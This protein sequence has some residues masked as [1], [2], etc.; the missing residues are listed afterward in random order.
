[1]EFNSGISHFS[2]LKFSLTL[3][4]LKTISEE[5][6][7]VRA[8]LAQGSKI[9]KNWDGPPANIKFHAVTLARNIFSEFFRAKIGFLLPKI[10]F[11]GLKLLKYCK[12]FLEA[13]KLLLGIGGLNE[14]EINAAK[15]F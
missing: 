2:I 14:Y 11:I 10:T 6:A 1:M 5:G 12:S 15:F 3:N 7:P 9:G 13:L 8:K 4:L